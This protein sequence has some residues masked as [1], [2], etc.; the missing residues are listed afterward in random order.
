MGATV[1]FQDGGG[2]DIA[3][4]S[5]RLSLVIPTGATL[6]SHIRHAVSM[7]AGQARALW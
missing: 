6:L 1:F 3:T 7:M 4:L 5:R 2:N